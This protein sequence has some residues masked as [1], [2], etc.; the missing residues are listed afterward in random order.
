MPP[1]YSLVRREVTDSTQDDARAAF[2]GQ[3][4]LVVAGEQRRG[5]GRSARD[6]Q[7][8]PRAMAASLACRPEWDAADL[9][10]I[11]LLAGIAAGR[12][13][14]CGLKWPNDVWVADDKVGGILVESSEGI[15][16][17]GFGLNLWWP[18]A[19]DGYGALHS[20]DPGSQRAVELAERWADELLGL[21][22]AGPSDWPRDEYLAKSVTIGRDITW[23]PDG[24]GKAIDIAPDGGLIVTTPTGQTL[25]LHAGEVRHVR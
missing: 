2:A 11:P 25:T 1:P 9:P 23:T 24:I 4:V 22:D 16:V 17:T 21:I 7:T 3:S 12:V 10:L 13:I 5:R 8:A 18:D 15:V 19:P 14:D 20:D 6:W